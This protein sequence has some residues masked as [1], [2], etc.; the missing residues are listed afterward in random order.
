MEGVRRLYL[1]QRESYRDEARACAQQVNAQKDLVEE[2]KGR[3]LEFKAKLKVMEDELDKENFGRRKAEEKVA[4]LRPWAT[5]GR[6]SVFSIGVGV[7]GFGIA[8]GI[9]AIH[10]N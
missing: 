5:A 9:R 1:G 10:G 7:A 2:Y 4:K 8:S 3:E 6:V